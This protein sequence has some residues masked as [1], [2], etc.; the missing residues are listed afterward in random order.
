MGVRAKVVCS[1]LA[2]VLGAS[3]SLFAL[4]GCSLSSGASAEQSVSTSR[5]G[6]SAA[7]QS[8]GSSSPASSSPAARPSPSSSARASSSASARGDGETVGHS[9]KS[10]GFDLISA[11]VVP[12]SGRSTSEG[13]S[14][15]VALHL[16]D[17]TYYES[18]MGR[19]GMVPVTVVV[20]DGMI[21]RI[22]V[23][24]NNETPAMSEKAQNTVIPEII[25][26]QSTDVDVASGA[27]MT[28]E[29]I[30]Q[31]VEQVIARAS[32]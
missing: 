27:T 2:V 8:A 26:S 5:V 25:A 12:G 20:D 6:G 14:A 1:G 3:C 19:V 22:S 17:G 24:E 30:I 29:A 13:D 31:A 4:S 23:G 9:S 7:T 21:T 10:D 28:S 15:P 18:A 32:E 16:K 11:S